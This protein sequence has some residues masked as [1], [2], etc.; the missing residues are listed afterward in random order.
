M[1]RPVWARPPGISEL[2]RHPEL[3]RRFSASATMPARARPSPILRT[4]RVR[5]GRKPPHLSRSARQAHNHRGIRVSRRLASITLDNLDD[6]PRRCLKFVF[7]EL[8][9]VSGARADEAG[10][11]QMEKES[12]ISSTLL[13]WGSCGKLVYV[14]GVSAGYVLYA[15]PLYVPRS[16][17][18]PTS[19]LSADAVLLM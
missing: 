2:M 6:L 12:W 13:E 3:A 18:F 14:D 19:P 8:D 1:L 15:P 17:A 16:V 5:G 9:P 10:G 4:G 7:W 11:P